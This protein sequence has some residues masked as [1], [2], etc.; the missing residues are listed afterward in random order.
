[1]KFIGTEDDDFCMILRSLAGLPAVGSVS[2]QSAANYLLFRVYEAA[3]QLQR[4]TPPGIAVAII[5][6]LTWWRFDFPLKNNYIDW[7]RPGFLPA[8]SVWELFVDKQRRR[9][10]RSPFGSGSGNP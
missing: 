5:E 2:P 1:M 8:D 3:K 6:D 9:Y 10:P 4:A 7:R